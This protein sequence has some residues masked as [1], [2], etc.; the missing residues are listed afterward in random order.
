MRENGLPRPSRRVL[1]TLLRMRKPFTRSPRAGKRLFPEKRFR[2]R[3]RRLFLRA[4]GL[5]PGDL[6]P[7]SLDAFIEFGHGQKIERLADLESR[8]TRRVILFAFH[9]RATSAGFLRSL[10]KI[11]LKESCANLWTRII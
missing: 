2:R 9:H 10:A 8:G 1:R 11:A 3:A 5:E 4:L 6:L 7:Q